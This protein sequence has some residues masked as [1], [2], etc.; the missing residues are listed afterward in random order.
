[1]TPIAL[2]LLLTLYAQRG[3]KKVSIFNNV[4]RP[5]VGLCLDM[6]AA[7]NSFQFRNPHM[8]YPSPQHRVS[9]SPHLP[10]EWAKLFLWMT[11][12]F[13]YSNFEGFD[14]KSVS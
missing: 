12:P 5:R 2:S 14:P 3:D 13:S 7:V 11:P 9:P 10:L 6:P 8:K 4:R 1:V